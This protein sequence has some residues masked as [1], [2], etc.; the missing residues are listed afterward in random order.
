VTNSEIKLTAI[1][2]ETLQTVIT[3]C[4]RYNEHRNE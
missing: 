4:L 1:A 3:K 2:R